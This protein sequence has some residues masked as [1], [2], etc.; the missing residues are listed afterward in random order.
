MIEIPNL[1]RIGVIVTCVVAFL[2]CLAA[3]DLSATVNQRRALPVGT[4]FDEC[5]R[6]LDGAALKDPG[7]SIV[8]DDLSRVPRY[9]HAK[10]N[11]N[12]RYQP[13]AFNLLL[14]TWTDSDWPSYVCGNLPREPANCVTSIQ[15]SFI[16]CNP[17]LGRQFASPLLHS[18]IASAEVEF[19]SKYILLTLLGHELGHLQIH[20]M[21]ATRHLLPQNRVDGMNCFKHL[22]TAETEEQIADRIGTQI[23]CTAL[24]RS[25]ELKQLPQSPVGVLQLISRLEDTLD[26]GYFKMDDVCTG[27]KDYPSMSRRKEMFAVSYLD[28]LYPSTQAEVKSLADEA[29]QAVKDLESWLN[30]R[31]LSGQLASPTYGRAPQT[32]GFSVSVGDPNRYVTFDSTDQDSSLWFLDSDTD[33]R[34]RYHLLQQWGTTGRVIKCT[35]VVGGLKV[36]IELDSKE[37]NSSYAIA[38]ATVKCD[39]GGCVAQLRSTNLP[40][41]VRIKPGPGRLF[42]LLSLDSVLRINNEDDLFG[43]HAWHWSKHRLGENVLPVVGDSTVG[44]FTAAKGGLYNVAI[45]EGESVRWRVL[46]TYPHETGTL[47]SATML[48]GRLLLVF[49]DTPL[50]GHNSLSLWDCPGALLLMAEPPSQ[51]TCSRF[52][53]PVAIKTTLAVATRDLASIED[54]RIEPESRCGGFV[55]VHHLGWLW[56][57]HRENATADLLPGDGLIGCDAEL[58]EART[59]RARRIDRL[60]L[61]ISPVAKSSTTLSILEATERPKSVD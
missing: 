34:L 57:L 26:E 3:E 51:A 33:G 60:I 11:V 24:R 9:R 56:L 42:L 52:A 61:Q 5:V 14:P 15:E 29:M 1:V 44:I 27:D 53:A 45:S 18:G 55:V 50:A 25:P 59:F 40:P 47:E 16:I 6:S 28:C 36:F 8:Q 19:A 37:E 20:S 31:Q 58:S 54:R 23:A 10:W 41:Q 32:S 4:L 49:Y 17:A 2:P 7:F 30:A 48:G 12:R 39:T 38:E 13:R 22:E 46:L 21:S 43:S 35:S